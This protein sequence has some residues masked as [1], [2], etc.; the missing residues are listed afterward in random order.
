MCYNN[1]VS[2]KDAISH[3]CGFVWR[4]PERV[5]LEDE[6]GGGKNKFEEET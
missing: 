2:E 3:S 4:L 5:L 6:A 1:L